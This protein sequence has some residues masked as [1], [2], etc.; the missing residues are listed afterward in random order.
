MVKHVRQ[1]YIFRN[2]ASNVVLAQRLEINKNTNNQ[3]GFF[4][5]T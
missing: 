4:N 3:K 2:V 1:D 5:N